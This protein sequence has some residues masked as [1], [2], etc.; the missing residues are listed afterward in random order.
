MANGRSGWR[1]NAGGRA[2]AA[3][4]LVAMLGLAGAPSANAAPVTQ[5][6]TASFSL[7]PSGAAILS[8]DGFDPASPLG[9]AELRRVTVS[10]NA[11]VQAT[12]L[13]GA[14]PGPNGQPLPYLFNLQI[15]QSFTNLPIGGPD[16]FE[17]FLPALAFTTGQA[18]GSLTPAVAVATFSY[19][20]HFDAASD[21][22]GGL[23]FGG[24]GGGFQA[25]LADFLPGLL[26]GPIQ[27]LTRFTATQ[28]GGA[29]TVTPISFAGGG[30]LIVQYDGETVAPVPA[31]PA[32]LLLATG[33]A[34]LGSARRRQARKG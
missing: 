3:G 23:A 16:G 7:D 9:P 4:A 11:V 32:A 10:V 17:S 28:T 31:P 8:Y 33:L 21:L 24:T 1:P 34:A 19:G 2:L 27:S 20:F 22:A 15:G 30:A 5:I 26:S 12:V 13:P 14:N 29:Q 25:L 6:D 18:T